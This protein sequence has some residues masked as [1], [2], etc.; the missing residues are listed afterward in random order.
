[1]HRRP[2][3]DGPMELTTQGVAVS[4]SFH[5]YTGSTDYGAL[6]GLRL[7][8]IDDHFPQRTLQTQAASRCFEGDLRCTAIRNLHAWAQNWS[9]LS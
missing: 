3:R 8:S 1:M 7:N 6:T 2:F 9:I 5:N 4:C